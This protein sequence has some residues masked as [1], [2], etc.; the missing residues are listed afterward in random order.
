MRKLNPILSFNLDID[1]CLEPDK[2]LKIYLPSDSQAAS[3]SPAHVWSSQGT[4]LK[5]IK[6][7]SG[8]RGKESLKNLCVDWDLSETVLI[9][10]NQ[11]YPRFEEQLH[12]WRLALGSHAPALCLFQLQPGENGGGTLMGG[13]PHM[14]PHSAVL[15]PTSDS[16]GSQLGR[17]PLA[18][19]APFYCNDLEL[20]EEAGTVYRAISSSERRAAQL[21]SHA[22]TLTFLHQRML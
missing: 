18:F 20:R 9:C 11:K 21:A 7:Q 15:R 1:P 12:G 6:A 4:F 5:Q 19:S 2:T 8:I 16:S 22:P 17:A 10:E 3:V 14:V 13:L